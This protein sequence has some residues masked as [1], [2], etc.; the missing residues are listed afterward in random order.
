MK[1]I[2]LS[3]AGT[4]ISAPQRV[5]RFVHYTRLFSDPDFLQVLWVTFAFTILTVIPSIAIALLIA[6]LL[7]SR[8]RGVKF[9][10][11]AFALPFAFS[12]A[13]ASVI[14]GV[15]FNPASGVLNGILNTFGIGKVNWLTNPTSP[16]VSVSGATVDADRL[17]L[18]VLSAGSAPAPRTPRGGPLDG[19]PAATPALD[20]HAAAHAA[21]VLPHRVGTIHS[22][23]SFGQIKIL[24]VGG[25][26]PRRRSSTRST[27]RPS[28]QQQHYG[29]A[30]AQAMLLL[31][32]VLLITALQF[33]V[34]REA[35]VLPVTSLTTKSP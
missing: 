27:S 14:F 25:P 9:F 23:Q 13:T 18:L 20:R 32:I 31:I 11:T 19:R 1:S 33:G 4:D 3:F 26:E 17:Q 8:I 22:L 34:S 24:T 35:G 10:R 6:L 2:L 21:A 29:Y 16:S 15:L 7:Q 28:P 12:V 30:S 5:R